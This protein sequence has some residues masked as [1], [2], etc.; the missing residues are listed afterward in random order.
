[1]KNKLNIG[2]RDVVLL[3]IGLI[4]ILVA[5]LHFSKLPT[6]LITH[7]E[8]SGGINRLLQKKVALTIMSIITLS[9]PIIFKTTLNSDPKRDNTLKFES[10]YEL[11]RICIAI[12]LSYLFLLTILF[13][14]GYY[15]GFRN[16]GI[17]LV[18]I[19]FILFGNVLTRIRFNYFLG[20]RTPWTLSNEEIWRRTHR[21]SGPVFIAAGLLMMFSIAFKN[22]FWVIL[23]T[24]IIIVLIPTGYSYLISRKINRPT[25][26]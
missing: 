9:F 16:W 2:L 25:N 17:P 1:V 5:I 23:A 18:G 8:F 4:P 21:F 12:L 20:I 19:F 11:M 24:F 7:I 15:N 3:L 6:Q 13:N 26:P 22:P 14:L 10:I